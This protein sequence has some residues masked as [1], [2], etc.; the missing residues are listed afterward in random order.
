MPIKVRDLA[1]ELGVSNEDVLE[2]L[3]KLY[4]D[5][6][7]QNSKIDDKI[8]GLVR[9]KLGG[10]ATAKKPA[11]EKKK[12]KAAIVSKAKAPKEEKKAKA[13]PAKKKEK[14]E[15]KEKVKAKLP[16]EKELKEKKVVK[17]EAKTAVKTEP[18]TPE[19]QS[20]TRPVIIEKAKQEVKPRPGIEIIEKGEKTKPVVKKAW[21]EGKTKPVIEIIEKGLK[22]KSKFWRPRR[23]IKAGRFAKETVILGATPAAARKT[24]QKIQMCVPV[25]IRTLAP[26][27]NMK[28][29][30]IIQ[31]LMGKGALVNINQDLEEDVVRDVMAHFGYELEIPETIESMEKDLLAESREAETSAKGSE[32]KA[33]LEKRAPVVTFMGHV[34]HGKTSLLDYIRKTMVTKGEKGGIT[35]HIGAYKVET[36]GGSV[37]FLDTPG[38]AAFTAM[39]ARGAHATDVVVLVVAADDGVMPQTKEAI[40]HA[41]AADVP[42]VVAIN[43]CDLASANPDK[44][45]KELQQENLVP[46]EWGGETIM[47]E[48]SAQTG[49]GVDRLVEMLM[50]ESEMLEL[51]ANPKI[52]ARGVVI[53]GKKTPGQGVVATLLVQNGTLCVGDIVLCG[54]YY[55]KVKAMINDVGDKVEAASPATPVEVLGLQG[56]PDAGEEFFVVK[57]EKKARTLALLKQS[58]SRKEKMAGS[59]RVTLEDLHTRIISE[60]MKELKMVLKADVQGS[61]EALKSSLVELSTDE[62]KLNIIHAASGNIN[63]SDAMLAM[64]S[65]A[66]IIGFHVKVDTKAGELAK[67]EKIDIHTYDVIY[68]AIADVHAGMEGLLEPE[69]RE[70]FQGSAQVREVFVTSKSGKVAGCAVLKGTIHRKDRVK[71]KRGQETVYEGEINDLK[72]FKDDVKEVKEGFE[73]GISIR[74][75]G[76]IRKNDIIEAFI[77]EKVARRLEK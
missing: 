34:D 5:V 77:I 32:E 26:R 56:V 59:Q 24:P 64:V 60:G 22:G 44:V 3:R 29:N 39:R 46:E 37:T 58:Q 23:G 19:E 36:S 63:E 67:K 73:C 8:V 68:E 57:D 38:H 71:V 14:T 72:R 20:T 51:K 75:F 17:E 4:V 55:G 52:R 10:S 31:Y 61:V 30:I 42:I 62:V 12:T 54:S 45:K 1:K 74:G 11:E 66:V 76:N 6:E 33:G 15:E 35:Q 50:L 28:P 65:N 21:K 43:K 16:D 18:K 2:Q 27:I 13:L 53:E 40:D 48:V 69:L 70:V 49:E 25:N 41:R 7:D 47:I 9:I